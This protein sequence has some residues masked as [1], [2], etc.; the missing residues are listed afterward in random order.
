MIKKYLNNNNK[1]ILIISFALILIYSLS[2]YIYTPFDYAMALSIDG[3]SNNSSQIESS[4]LYE[5]KTK[6]NNTNHFKDILVLYN[7]N[8]IDGNNNNIQYNTTIIINDGKIVDIINKNDINKVTK[9]NIYKSYL[10]S[11]LIDLS[12]NYI[13]PGF[14]I[15]IPHVAGVLNNSINKT[16]SE[17]CFIDF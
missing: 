3:L 4:L 5:V 15:C 10:N 16:L 12:G 8:L 14:L 11:K 1:K 17:K 6:Q 2:A 9:T 7:V 13:I